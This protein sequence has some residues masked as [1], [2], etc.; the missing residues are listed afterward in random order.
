MLVDAT[1][2]C[3]NQP[4][5]IINPSIWP[6]LTSTTIFVIG[7]LCKQSENSNKN[8]TPNRT[9]QNPDKRKRIPPA[10]M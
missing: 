6:P 1:N 4:K 8:M 9:E 3:L 5:S 2:C 10:R 7:C